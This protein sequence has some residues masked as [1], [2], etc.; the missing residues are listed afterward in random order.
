MPEYDQM[1]AD[2]NA[3][4]FAWMQEHADDKTWAQFAAVLLTA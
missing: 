3:G 2:T 4:L 1:Q